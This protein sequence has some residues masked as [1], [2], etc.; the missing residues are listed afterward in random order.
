MKKN[1][2]SLLL[3]LGLITLSFNSLFAQ[4]NPTTIRTA[5]SH[6]V[7]IPVRD[8]PVIENKQ[9][10]TE[11]EQQMRELN[12]GLK[13]RFYP[14]AATALPQGADPVWQKTAANNTKALGTIIDNFDGQTSSSF[15]PD[16]SGSVGAGYFFEAYNTS[17]AIYDLSGTLIT[18]P[19]AYNTLFNGVLGADRNDGDP[20]ILWDEQAGRWFASEFSLG[21]NNYML[22]AVSQTSDPTGAWDAWSFD[23]D[24]MPDYMKFGVWEDGYYMADNNSSGDDIYVFERSV[25]LAGGASPQMIGFNNPYRPNSGFHCIMPLDC[26]GA[27]APS[28]TPG[29]FMTINDDAWGGSDELWIYELDANWSNTSSSTFNRTQQ[30]S[31]P[32]FDAN[33][34]SSWDNISQPGTSQKLDA[35]P[36]ILM[37][38][39]QYRNFGTSQNMVAVHAVDVD[40]SDHSGLRWYELQNTG[41]TWSVRQSGT[42]APDAASR[43]I[44][45]IAMNGNHEIGMAYSISDAS[46]NIYPGIRFT[47]QTAGENAAASGIMD[48]TE[49]SAVEGGTYQASY[50]RWGDYAQL[51]IDPNNDNDFWFNSEYMQSNNSIK[52]TRIVGFRFTETGDPIGLTATAIASDQIDLA[53][54][55]N[56]TSD[57]ALV[58]WS[59]NGT[60]GT[61]V[62]GTTYS[63]GQAIPGGG[64]VLTYGAAISYNHTGLSENTTYYYKAWSYLSNSTYSPGVIAN[65]TTP[66]GPVSAFP[67]TWDFESSTDYTQNF[68]PWTT[69]DINNVITYSSSDAD[70]TGEGTAFAWLAMNPVASGW[71]GSS[72][73]DD[74][75]GGSRCGLSSCPS[76]GST[77]DHWFIS[78]PLQLN[79]GSSF[80]L[81]ALTPKDDYGLSNFEILVSTTDNNTSSFTT[82]SSTEDAPATWTQFT[83]DLSAYDNQTIF[84]AIRDISPDIFLLWIDDLEITSTGCTAPSISSQPSGTVVCLGDNTSFTVTATNADSYQWQLNGTN[85][86]GATSASL[87]INGVT[88]ADGGSYTCIVTNT[89]GDVTTTAATL[90]VSPATAI[91]TQPNGGTYCEGDNV[92]LS[93]TS[94]GGGLSYQWQLNGSNV[95]GATSAS[96]SMLASTSNN[97]DYTCI[98]NGDCGNATSNT[99]TVNVNAATVISTQPNS[100]S[101]CVGDNLNLSISASGTSVSYQWQFNGSDISGANSD[102]YTLPSLVTGNAGNYTCDI[103]GTC[104]NITSNTANVE[105]N[106]TISITTQP[107]DQVIPLGTTATFTVSTT[108]SAIGY[109]WY[110]DGSAISNGGNISGATSATLAITNT[111]GSNLGNYTCQITGNCGNVTSNIAVLDFTN[112]IEDELPTG[113]SIYPNPTHGDLLIEADGIVSV[114]IMDLAG[115]TILEKEVNANSVSIDLG[116]FEEGAYMIQFDY[117]KGTYT[118]KINKLN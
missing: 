32:S 7:T 99:A 93:V 75:H 49:T 86:S 15:P 103:T 41:T 69:V 78:P 33:F 12:E 96:Y 36:Q 54:S 68:A 70:F 94:T 43:W 52:G 71:T 58:A 89:C 73:G 27:F 81:W 90:T 45:S 66:S 18:G 79:A 53:W 112:G 20:I 19:T 25:M 107:A 83:Y 100:G 13:D 105:V 77:A 56:S 21:S 91:S 11:E 8:M 39:V 31:V 22:I 42:Y 14:Y 2:T 87:N 10:L 37:Y 44:G 24:D 88:N 72:Q 106:T 9:A 63:A 55:L 110:L 26:D 116:N 61:P 60:F 29:Q 76:D 115:R 51:S 102:T 3:L 111:T 40:G 109:Q 62:D 4:V 108:G 82:I 38:R 117:A 95:S 6:V 64:I 101:Y 118:G 47:G 46:N 74:A 23:V 113:I 84:I 28:G 35:I 34:G 16:C 65:A 104:G 97:G 48:V 114:K 85:V 98:I 59:A 92:S 50:N 30:L 80:S 1:F 67:F 5:N 17:F 57:N